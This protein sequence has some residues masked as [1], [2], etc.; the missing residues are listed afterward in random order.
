MKLT[1]DEPGV[2]DDAHQEGDVEEKGGATNG[3]REEIGKGH[4]EHDWLKDLRNVARFG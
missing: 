3:T 1:D 4:T 2:E